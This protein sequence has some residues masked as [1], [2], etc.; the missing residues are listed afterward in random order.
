MVT[1]QFL[2]A[3]VLFLKNGNIMKNGGKKPLSRAFRKLGLRRK[4]SFGM[5]CGTS[6]SMLGIA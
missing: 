6:F 5:I 3:L 1:I 4:L 2:W